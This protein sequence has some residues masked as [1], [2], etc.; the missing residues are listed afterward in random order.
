[1]YLMPLL[2]AGFFVLQLDR[3]NIGNALTD[4]LT[5]DLGIT[6]DDV[7][8]GNQFMSAGIVIAEIPLNLILQRVGAPVWL[9]L[10]ML[11]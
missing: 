10:Q 3:S 11:I 2:M 5:T 1:M 9:T 8:V 6:T 4:T 7:N